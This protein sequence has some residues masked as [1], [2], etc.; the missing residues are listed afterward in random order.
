MPRSLPPRKQLQHPL[1]PHLQRLSPRYSTLPLA[2]VRQLSPYR[3]SSTNKVC[4]LKLLAV[5]K[6]NVK[7]KKK[8]RPRLLSV[9]LKPSQ[10]PAAP[11]VSKSQAP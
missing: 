6:P 8:L 2:P 11:K 1:L 10:L 4:R 5:P 9:L 7:P 3:P